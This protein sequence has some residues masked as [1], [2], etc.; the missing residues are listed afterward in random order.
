M[1][2]QPALDL[3]SDCRWTACIREFPIAASKAGFPLD[4][5]TDPV[6]RFHEWLAAAGKV[7]ALYHP[8]QG[9]RRMDFALDDNDV[10]VDAAASL[11]E[12]RRKVCVTLAN[13][14][15][16]ECRK[17][18]VQV[19]GARETGDAECIVLQS[20]DCLPPSNFTQDTT[21]IT[22]DEDGTFTVALPPHGVARLR[23][24]V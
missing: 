19:V 3:A 1:Q 10:D 2:Q 7:F 5:S 4:V 17:V 20:D 9:N 11:D 12:G 23:F 24:G 21:T 6:T 18:R 14:G 16:M 13:R 22:A 8:H 15:P